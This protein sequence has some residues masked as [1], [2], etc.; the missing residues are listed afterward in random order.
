[1]EF[2]KALYTLEGTRS[3]DEVLDT[4]PVK[5]TAEMNSQLLAPFDT[6]EV[7]AALFQM[8][9]TKAPVPDGYP[10]H[11]FSDIGSCVV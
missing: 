8:F 9:P 1:M 11:F 5:V 7:K 2:Y 10:A 3:V 6:G 4:V